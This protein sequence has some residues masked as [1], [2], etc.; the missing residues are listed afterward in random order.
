MKKILIL[1]I[2]LSF[3]LIFI[4]VQIEAQDN[5]ITLQNSTDCI[6]NP[7]ADICK[8][9]RLRG[10]QLIIV[11][12]I[13]TIWVLGIPMFAGFGMLIG[14]QYMTSAGDT[15]KQAQLRQKGGMWLF[16]I[17][18]FFLSQPIAAAI[19][20]FFITENDQ[21]FN[22]APGFTIFFPEICT[23]T[24]T[25]NTV[26]QNISSSADGI[27]GC[28]LLNQPPNSLNGCYSGDD[29]SITFNADMC[30]SGIRCENNPLNFRDINELKDTIENETCI[31]EGQEKGI[32]IN[33]G[34]SDQTMECKNGKWIYEGDL[35]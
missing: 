33:G 30:S 19:M 12:L 26:A 6:A 21:C 29:C 7:E 10:V 32:E 14:Y 5:S 1:T 20:G 8:P 23:G 24:S 31:Y 13:Y 17:I 2:I 27:G 22:N 4:P 28:C 18:L 35:F 15:D 34:L 16:S 25:T 11:N 3:F 9:G